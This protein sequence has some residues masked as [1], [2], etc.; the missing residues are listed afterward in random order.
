M[1]G[2]TFSLSVIVPVYN[3]EKYLS[4]CIESILNQTYK[5]FELILVDDGSTDNSRNICEDYAQKDSRI[6]V[7][8]QKNQGVIKARFAGADESRGEYITFVDADD[9]IHE[10]MYRDLMQCINTYEVDIVLS[11]LYRYLD[12][13]NIIDF[14]HRLR[15]GLYLKSDLEKEVIPY[16]L[17]DG[18]I[19][20]WKVDPSLC[21][22]IFKRDILIHFMQNSSELDIYYGEDTSIIFPMLLNAN[23]IYVLHKSYYYHRQR[24]TG[25]AIPYIKDKSFFDK[26]YILYQYLQ[27]VFENSKYA[28][29]M[30]RQLE[31][32]YMNSIQLKKN[33]YLDVRES[34]KA[35]FPFWKVEKS[36]RVILYGAGLYGCS[37]M[38]Q[39]EQQR[40]CKIVAW[41]DKNYEKLCARGLN[42]CG[43]SVIGEVEYDYILLAVATSGLAVQIR[44][45]LQEFGVRKDKIIWSAGVIQELGE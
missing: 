7:I 30:Q 37:Y 25:I 19:Q 3:A 23:S 36:S 5:E 38:E 18:T 28:D 2:D 10:G 26:L 27:Q 41:V 16:M 15:E 13:D 6:K 32:F 22:K 43:V 9:W 45:E 35:V 1:K 24:E 31:L 12:E 4:E 17:W 42:V 29:I 39:N 20:G 33:T 40:F 21:S 14:K 34:K 44:E 8:H 11:G